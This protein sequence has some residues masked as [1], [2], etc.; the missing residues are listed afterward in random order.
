MAKNGRSIWERLRVEG[1]PRMTSCVAF[2]ASRVSLAAMS[3][4]P[5]LSS[6][7]EAPLLSHRHRGIEAPLL[8]HGHR[9]VEAPLLSHRQ[10]GVEAPLLSHRHR[11]VEA[12]LLSHRH[13]GV[14]VE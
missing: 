12:P 7:A 10:R 4:W 1:L 9:G 5:L 11:G 13:R 6:A 3:P 8:S 2:L 14:T